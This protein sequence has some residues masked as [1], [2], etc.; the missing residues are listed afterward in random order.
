MQSKD[1]ERRVADRQDHSKPLFVS[2]DDGGEDDVD[3]DDDGEEDVDEDDDGEDQVGE[4]DDG[5]EEA[6][7]NKNISRNSDYIG[8]YH[9]EVVVM[10]IMFNKCSRRLRFE[11]MD[12]WDKKL[13]LKS[14]F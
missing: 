3:K 9:I 2:Q 8:D 5:E 12:D 13:T 7:E 14:H 11:N 10:A 4:D 1:R 6:D